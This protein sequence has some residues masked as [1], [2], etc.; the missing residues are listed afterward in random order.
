LSSGGGSRCISSS[1]SNSSSSNISSCRSSAAT[2]GFDQAL[3]ENSGDSLLGLHDVKV[4][5][6]HVGC[7]PLA[8]R[9]QLDAVSQVGV[10]LRGG[11]G[12]ETVLMDELFLSVARRAGMIVQ[13]ASSRRLH[14]CFASFLLLTVTHKVAARDFSECSLSH[15]VYNL[16]LMSGSVTLQVQRQRLS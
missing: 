6:A 13:I 15:A 2:L 4:T 16:T 10:V 14:A 12:G 5:R 8:C 1:S 3:Q 7:Q 9:R 11:G